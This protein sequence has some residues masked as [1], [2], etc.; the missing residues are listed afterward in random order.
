MNTEYPQMKEEEVI[1]G[2]ARHGERGVRYNFVNEQGTT[3]V[4]WRSKHNVHV[5]PLGTGVRGTSTY[6][7]PRTR[8]LEMKQSDYAKW[9]AAQLKAECKARGLKVS[10]TKAQL[11]A[12]LVESDARGEEE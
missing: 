8:T 5:K 2:L 3:C 6:N 12:R 4:A 7:L 11:N 10:G 1:E 9:S